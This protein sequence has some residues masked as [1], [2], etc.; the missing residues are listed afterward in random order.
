MDIQ[1]I[2]VQVNGNQRII[3]PVNSPVRLALEGLHDQETGLPYLAAIVNNDVCSLDYPL[4]MNCEIEPISFLDRHG[5]R[6][7]RRT[8]SFLLAKAVIRTFPQA[9]FAVEHSLGNGYYCSFQ[10]N[11]HPGIRSAELQQIETCLQGLISE[12]LPIH[13]RSISYAE[14]EQRLMG[15]GLEDKLNLL[16]YRNPPMVTMYECR[17]FADAGLGVIAPSTGSV[18]LFRL[19]DYEPGF[20]LQFPHWNASSRKLELSEFKR[21]PHLFQVFQDHKKWGK[22]IGVT[23]VGDL[24]QLVSEKKEKDFIRISE[25]RHEKHLGDIADRISRHHDRLKWI[26]VAGPSSAGKTTTSKRLMVHLQVNGLRPVR[27]ELDN[28]FRGRSRTPRHPD[29]SYDFEHLET[30]DLELLNDHLQKLDRGEE[31]EVPTFN[32]LTGEPEYL[33]NKMK[34]EEDQVVVIEGIHALNPRLTD[35]LPASHKFKIFINA[36]TQ[37]KLDNHNRLSTTDLRLIRR[38]VRDFNHR[39]HDA[40]Q[41]LNMWPSV[42]E[43]EKRWI[44]PFQQEADV[45]FNSSLDYELAVLKPFVEPLLHAVKPTHSVYGE[46]RRLQDFLSVVVGTTPDQVP[47]HS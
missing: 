40:V 9:R 25:T 3:L 36:L 1:K 10:M 43:G 39:G 21:M 30:I 31:I 44:Y 12:N 13:R 46:A 20:V 18:P 6:V 35:Q 8:L 42:R 47:P 16:K 11:G 17:D 14:A 15:Q 38:I 7:Y 5:S 19:L 33:G 27:M 24:N 45:T 4:G 23:T 37:L 34:L 2:Q 29:G 28:Y 22:L 26:L 32:F 41:T